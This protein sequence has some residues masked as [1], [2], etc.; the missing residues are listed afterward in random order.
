MINLDLL[1]FLAVYTGHLARIR[2]SQN[3]LDEL[4]LTNAAKAKDATAL[5]ATTIS[6]GSLDA[7]VGAETEG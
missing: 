1:F 6:R 2:L 7:Y 5:T 4:R 3:L